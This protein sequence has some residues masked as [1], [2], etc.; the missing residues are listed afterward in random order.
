MKK[1]FRKLSFRQSLLWISLIIGT[2]FF[3]SCKDDYIYDDQEPEW[4]GASIYDYLKQNGNYNYYVAIIDELEYTEVLQKT[5]SKTVFVA[6]DAAFDRFFQDNAWGVSSFEQMTIAQKKLIL[7]FGTINN[8]YL[9]ETLSNYNNG[10]LKIGKAMR[11]ETAVDQLDS[12][13]F[14]QGDNLPIGPYWDKYKASGIHLL[15]G[16]GTWP[17]VHFLQKQM[18][19][20]KIT[21]EDFRIF[22]GVE[23]VANDAHIFSNKVIER[24]ITCKNGYINVLDEVLIPPSNMAQ[25]IG[26]NP[27][28]EIFSKLLDR[29]SAPYYVPEETMRYGLSNPGFTD[30]IFVKGY[31]S[32]VGGPI[33]YPNGSFINPELYLPFN[34]GWNSYQRLEAGFGLQEDMAAIFAPTN[35]AM[36]A[37]F[38]S[39]SG[40][41]LK[42]RYG[43]WD[44]VPNDILALFLK[45]HLK[46]SFI[47]SVPSRFAKMNDEEN[48]RLP[49]EKEDVVESSLGVNGAVYVTSKVYPPDDYVSIYG[50]VLFSDKTQIFNWAIRQNDFRLYLN[51]LIS[52]YSLFV[53]TDEFFTNYIDPFTVGKDV[54][55]ALR[56]WFNEETEMVNA[57]VYRY[58]VETNEMGDSV[59]AIDNTDFLVNRLLDMLDTHIIIGGV[60]SGDGYY[61]SKGGNTILVSGSGENMKIQG[62]GDIERGQTIGVSQIYEQQNGLTYFIDKP[63]QTPL[64]SVYKLLSETP[65][66]NKF[67]EL[68]NGFPASSISQIFVKKVNYFGID[69]SV[70]FLNTFNY[71][72]YVPTNQAIDNAITE[73]LFKPW[74]SQDGIIGIEDI[75]D[76][77]ERD[78]AIV[79]LERFLRYHFQDNSV[80]ISDKPVNQ[81]YQS[82]TIKL[83]GGISKFNTFKNKYYKIGVTS[84]ANGLSLVTENSNTAHVVTE[85]NLYNILTRD[86]IFNKD[87]KTFLQIDGSGSGL[88]Y[89]TSQISTSS[90]AVIHQIDKVLTFE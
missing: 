82:A 61:F 34:P 86:Y 60:E 45:R 65:E 79:Q 89:S 47:E 7:N 71:T 50:P 85:N 9:I 29:F 76:I 57:T 87:P 63:I 37:Y 54:P 77:D 22:T 64:T 41:V 46:S 31:F 36:M 42:E 4:L 53:P 15:D 73:G 51:S 66:F 11:R 17:M 75:T 78:S 40:L 81:V 3:V 13:P 27:K 56:F 59:D 25:K 62:G 70:K 44:N 35:E 52:K 38:N 84:D 10:G 28:T 68:L 12:L 69:N 90:T 26:D 43:D 19:L 67:F 48:S 58:D 55:G 16:N 14:Y 20:A 33:R 49:V 5:G 8:A 23:R 30:S 88:N 21:D 6:D 80:Y 24:D 1:C 74:I 2:A 18:S 72:V 39:G 32:P 83:N